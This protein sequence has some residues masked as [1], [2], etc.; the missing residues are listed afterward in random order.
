MC[1]TLIRPV[2][3]AAITRNYTVITRTTFWLITP[4]RAHLFHT[5]TQGSLSL[6]ALTSVEHRRQFMLSNC[7][8][9][10]GIIQCWTFTLTSEAP[11]H[12]W[13]W[14]Q[15]LGFWLLNS[16]DPAVLYLPH[17]VYDMKHSTHAAHAACYF[18]A[19]LSALMSETCLD[20]TTHGDLS[21]ASLLSE[22]RCAASALCVGFSLSSCMRCTAVFYTGIHGPPDFS[23]M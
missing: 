15:E 11:M 12:Q 1:S 9:E 2:V 5:R 13:Q 19:D 21:A 18:H 22:V 20:I 10:Q 8:W 3:S 6:I 7:E 4:S 23:Y 14:V 16:P 17:S